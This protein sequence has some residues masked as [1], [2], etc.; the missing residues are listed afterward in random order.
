MVGNH[1]QILKNS[2]RK[3]CLGKQVSQQEEKKPTG[4]ANRNN[5]T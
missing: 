4:K 5:Q 3:S 1:E 2:Q